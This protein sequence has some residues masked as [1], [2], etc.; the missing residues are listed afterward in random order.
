MNDDLQ[1]RL[2]AVE[3]ATGARENEILVAFR[4]DD[5]QL[6]DE[7]GDPIPENPSRQV[8][9]ITRDTRVDQ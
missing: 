6:V 2:E 3:Q 7:N 9:V 8:V 5:G 4:S 1:D